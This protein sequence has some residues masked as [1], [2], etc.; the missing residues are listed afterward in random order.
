MEKV[1]GSLLSKTCLVYLDDVIIFSKT[2]QGMIDNLKEVFS[3]FRS[4]KLKMNPNKCIFM[5]REVKYLGHVVSSQGV[6]TDPEKISAVA[7]WPVPKD[8][9]ALRRFLGFC[10]YYRKFV[11]GFSLIA[12]PLFC[13]TEKLVRFEW[14]SQ[15]QEA[16]EALKR[17]LMSSPILS[18]PLE[19]G[20][21]ILDT[22]A[23]NHGVG[24][25]LSQVQVQ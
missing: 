7:E 24:A 1:L 9:K 2:F 22:D 6:T 4:A 3:R 8:K 20:E 19:K 12:K 10:L 11:K 16:F 14:T 18:F 15:C 25:V 13:L 17:A 5:K 23:S 21:F